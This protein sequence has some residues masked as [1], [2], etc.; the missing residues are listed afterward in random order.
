MLFGDVVLFANCGVKSKPSYAAKHMDGD[1]RTS[2]SVAN[3]LRE[4]FLPAV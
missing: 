3:I 4:F 2:R 1:V